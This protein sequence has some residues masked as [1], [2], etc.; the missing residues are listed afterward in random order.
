ML[1]EAEAGAVLR[2]LRKSRGL[3]LA[4]VARQAGCAESL[5]SYVESGRRRLQPW[6]AGR[7]DA[8]YRTGGAISALTAD[9]GS[10]VDVSAERVSQGELLFVRLPSEGGISMPLSRR[11]LLASL[12]AGITTGHLLT[13]FEKALDRIPI[14]D[15]SM[16]QF[17]DALDGFQSAARSLPPARVIDGLTSHVAVLE[18]LCRRTAGR[19]QLAWRRMQARYAESLSWL[20][21]ERGDL[22]AAIYWID[23]ASQWGQAS[24]WRDV[25]AYSFVR[26]SMLAISFTND[27]HRAVD[28]AGAAFGIGGVSPRVKGLAEKQM[29]FGYALVGDENA[30][31][32][33]LDRAMT[34]L[35]MPLRDSDDLLG[36]RSVVHD[37]L[38]AIFR[39]TCD[40]YLGRG[41]R[42]VPILRPR[43]T[44]LSSSSARTATITHAKLARAYA[45][46]GQPEEAA[47]EALT[48][49]DASEQLGSL[50]AR[51]ELRRALP[52]LHR[53]RRR[54]D[55]RAVLR[56]LT[57]I[58][59]D[60]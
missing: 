60:A 56:R 48:A 7:L 16:Q 15:C 27:G 13:E 52:V 20:S 31:L 11:E 23:R 17:E 9:A 59:R 26:R 55:I 51:S 30:S 32:R 53:W 19:Q 1:N 37:D 25:A 5:I 39:A 34:Y 18:M 10:A 14:D 24:G 28:N 57:P 42:V 8:I 29:A 2:N 43:L 36:Q 38:F 49:L 4:A 6:L 50:S 54:D 46:A 33:A 45:N 40:I 41:D 35:A 44:S 21:E 12:G 58:A 3:T 47:R 22:A